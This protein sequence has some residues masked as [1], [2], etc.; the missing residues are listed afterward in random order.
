MAL[1]PDSNETFLREVDENLRRDQMRDLGKKYGGWIIGAALLFLAAVGGWLYWQQHQV[2]KAQEDSEALA[3][4]YADLAANRVGT[5]PQ[6]LESIGQDATPGIEATTDFTRASLALQRNDRRT[7]IQI[8]RDLQANDRLP[9]PYREIALVRQTA[10]EFD[11]LK[12][13]EVVT[14]LAPLA[15]SGNPWFGSAGEMTAMAYLKQGKRAEAG[16]LFAA[17][18]ADQQVPP[19]IRARAVQIAGTLG[20]DASASMP[21][22][23]Q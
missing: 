5:A 16:K 20:I 1:P 17:V 23:A 19:S 22:A 7:A 4:V 21:T 14:R 15:K 3:A 11:S 6:R 10:L 9:E 12:P 2:T 8:Y 13:E 18:A